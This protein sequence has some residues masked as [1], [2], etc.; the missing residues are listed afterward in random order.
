M[1]YGAD[2]KYAVNQTVGDF[3]GEP[4]KMTFDDIFGL[5]KQAAKVSPATHGALED[6]RESEYLYLQRLVEAGVENAE[7]D[8][9]QFV[10]ETAT[11]TAR[12]NAIIAKVLG[13][14]Q[15]STIKTAAREDMSVVDDWDCYKGVINA[16]NTECNSLFNQRHMKHTRTLANMCNAGV[17]VETFT[18][19]ASAICN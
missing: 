10:V 11:T 12:I 19:A 6:T 9:H 14:E 5:A 7:E 17:D 15:V 8:L 2:V 1:E 16:Y 3:I 13:E 18:T 4:S